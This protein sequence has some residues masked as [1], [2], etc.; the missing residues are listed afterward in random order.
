MTTIK[1]ALGLL[2]CGVMGEVPPGMAELIDTSVRNASALHR[3]IDDLL[4]I[5][6]MEAGRLEYRFGR[7]SVDEVVDHAMELAG[8]QCP[9]GGADPPGRAAQRGRGA[10]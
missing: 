2:Q 7:A 5:Q 10:W 3:L 8:G 6:K 1:G 9:H 4:D